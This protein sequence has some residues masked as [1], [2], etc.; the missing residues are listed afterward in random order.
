MTV[1]VREL[2]LLLGMIIVVPH[3]GYEEPGFLSYT[4]RPF[5]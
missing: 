1:G 5:C 4:I 3:Q 2:V